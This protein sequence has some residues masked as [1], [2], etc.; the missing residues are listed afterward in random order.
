MLHLLVRRFGRRHVLDVGTNIGTTAMALDRAV[1]LNGGDCVTCDPH[2]YG[3]LPADGPRFIHGTSA[4]ALE[5]LEREGRRLDF[6]FFDWIPSLAT[7]KLMGRV[8][9][10]GAILAAHDFAINDKGQEIIDAV[11]VGYRH[12]WRGQ[13]FTLARPQPVRA[14]GLAIN[15]CTTYFLPDELTR[16]RSTLLRAQR[17]VRLPFI[18]AH[19]Y[20]RLVDAKLRSMVRANKRE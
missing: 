13:W 7:L 3:C 17:L 20:A 2:A 9:E 11:N 10:R 6:V 12:A 8:L 16:E 5:I 4:D 19:W 18:K 1:R 15:G 14:A